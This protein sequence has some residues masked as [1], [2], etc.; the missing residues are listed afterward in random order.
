MEVLLKHLKFLKLHCTIEGAKNETLQDWESRV[1][2]GGVAVLRPTDSS[3]I[4]KVSG[5]FSKSNLPND[6]F[7]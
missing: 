2:T 4:G 3:V 5:Y 7:T 6:H 1:K